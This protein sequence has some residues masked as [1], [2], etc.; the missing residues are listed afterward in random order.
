MVKAKLGMDDR[1]TVCGS[2]QPF[3]KGQYVCKECYSIG[4]QLTPFQAMTTEL[5]ERVRKYRWGTVDS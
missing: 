1:C 5:A 2:H 4:Q 3:R